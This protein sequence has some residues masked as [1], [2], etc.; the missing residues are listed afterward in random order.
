VYR[1][2]TV[3]WFGFFL[4][5]VILGFL[6]ACGSTPST[7]TS[8]SGGGSGTST[9]SSSSSGGSGTTAITLGGAL[10]GPFVAPSAAC[11][12]LGTAGFQVG[13]TGT[14]GASKYLLKFDAPKGTTDLSVKTTTNVVVLFIQLPSGAAWGADPRS[15]MGSGTLTVNGSAGGTV[16]LHLLPNVGTPASGTLDVSGTYSCS[17]STTG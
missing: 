16:D 3:G 15:G 9:S 13:I 2:R 14:V 1:R 6:S 4:W 8:S 5:L 11:V 7:G 10:S 12:D 17:S